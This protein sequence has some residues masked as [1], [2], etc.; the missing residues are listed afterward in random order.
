MKILEINK[1]HYPKGG[2]ERHYFDVS[3]VLREKGHKILFFS[4]K[5]KNN[6]E[7]HKHF[8]KDVSFS[9]FNL[10][11]IFRFF[12]NFESAK[13]LQDL[14]DVERPDIAHLH[15][16][17]HQLSPSIIHVLK[18]NNIPM[19]MTLHDYKIICPNYKLFHKGL[20]CEKCKNGKYY[21]CV[22]NK[23]VKNSFFKSLLVSIEAYLHNQ[24]LKSY[25]LIDFFIAPSEFMKKKC[26]EF[27]VN[28]K[29]I[30]TINNFVNFEANSYSQK[31]DYLLYFGRLSEEKGIEV[32][33]RAML[34]LHD[35]KLKIVGAGEN[36]PVLRALVSEL[37]LENKVEFLGAKHNDDLLNI[38]NDAQAII[39]P[40][41]WYENMPMNLL[42]AMSMGKIVIASNIGGIPE[43]IS[44]GKNGF[45][46]ES[47]NS[48]ELAEKIKNLS[49]YD[50]NN[51]K[52][53]AKNTVKKYSKDDYYFK[54]SQIFTNLTIDN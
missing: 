28:E 20:I 7:N 6:I 19:V 53:C 9:A 11:N 18:K 25:D 39:I 1:Y 49:Q 23:C 54:I 42:E 33:L 32:L 45:L 2:S 43:I 46:F 16:I 36:L 22:L 3:Q 24:I 50:L 21:N 8:A 4:T 29:K 31:E 12:Y 26:V 35:Y 30:I 17:Y 40:S 38:V 15:N 34:K 14:I 52:K 41:I 27:G 51:F 5:N 47:G 44:D 13:K 37:C 48:E 10:I